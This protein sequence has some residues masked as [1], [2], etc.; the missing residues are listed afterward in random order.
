ML[1]V[2]REH[3]KSKVEHERLDVHRL[4]PGRIG[5]FDLVFCAGVLYLRH[6]L[7]ALEKIRS[8]TPGRCIPEPHQLITGTARKGS[9][10][11]ILSG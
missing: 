1:S 6:P 10:D 7:L 5:T 4:D 9:G 8:V 2:A 3:F 11:H